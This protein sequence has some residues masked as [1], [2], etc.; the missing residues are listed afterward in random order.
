MILDILKQINNKIDELATKQ[1]LIEAK[2]NNLSENS[3]LLQANVDGIK[4][5][6]EAIE[7]EPKSNMKW[8]QTK[9]SYFQSLIFS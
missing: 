2:I 3:D 4:E 6:V 1:D 9:V 7:N 8:Y 5:K